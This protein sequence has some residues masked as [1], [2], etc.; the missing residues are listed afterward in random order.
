MGLA[1]R[2]VALPLIMVLLENKCLVCTNSWCRKEIRSCGW[3]QSEWP[4]QSDAGGFPQFLSLLGSHLMRGVVPAALPRVVG[5]AAH[6]A[7]VNLAAPGCGEAAGCGGGIWG[8]Q[9]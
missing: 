6:P 2:F 9:R 5:L 8:R 3:S 1:Q 4:G 7:T